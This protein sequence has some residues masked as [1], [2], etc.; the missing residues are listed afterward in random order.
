MQK[1]KLILALTILIFVITAGWQIGACELANI[2]LRDDMRDLSSQL[3]ARIGFSPVSSD[4]DFRAAVI[5]KAKRYNIEL[6]P[7]QVTIQRTGEG[8]KGTIYLQADY[9]VPI[10]LPGFD[11]RM[12]FTPESGKKPF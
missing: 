12:H 7:E 1:L 8:V 3:G 6:A 5:A 9:T 11:F 2:E 10:H 4:D